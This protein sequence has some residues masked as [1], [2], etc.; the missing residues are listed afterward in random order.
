MVRHLWTTARRYAGK[1]IVCAPPLKGGTYGNSCFGNERTAWP[2][3]MIARS[4][5]FQARGCATLPLHMRYALLLWIACGCSWAHGQPIPLPPDTLRHWATVKA[6]TEDLL[7]DR[8][9]LY[10]VKRSEA[11]ALRT[12]LATCDSTK[13][14]LGTIASNDSSLNAECRRQY[15]DLSK[16]TKRSAWAFRFAVILSLIHI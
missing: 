5:T 2:A 6:T 3:S 8:T 16:K 15:V 1:M 4:T 13:A 11:Y 14:A 9:V 12:A 10:A 7:H